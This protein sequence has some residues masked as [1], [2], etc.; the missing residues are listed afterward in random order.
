MQVV[1]HMQLTKLQTSSVWQR[2]GRGLSLLAERPPVC[3]FL[4]SADVDGAVIVTTPPGGGL[5]GTCAR[6]STSLPRYPP[7]N[8]PETVP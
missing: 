3:S 5:A 2:C 8:G 6:S 7:P 4:R 1:P